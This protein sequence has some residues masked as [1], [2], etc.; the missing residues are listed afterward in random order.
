[1]DAIGLLFSNAAAHCRPELQSVI[2]MMDSL[3]PVCTN[4]TSEH[5]LRRSF[6]PEGRV[7]SLLAC[8]VQRD[9]RFA[10]YAGL[11]NPST[12]KTFLCGP[13]PHTPPPEPPDAVTEEIV[14]VAVAVVVL[15]GIACWAVAR[16][17]WQRRRG[18][19]LAWWLALAVACG[20]TASK[21]DR[22][23]DVNDF[24]VR[25]RV[26]DCAFQV[27]DVV[28]R[29]VAKDHSFTVISPATAAVDAL[30]RVLRTPVATERGP[31]TLYEEC[32][33]CG[34]TAWN[35]SEMPSPSLVRT[36]ILSDAPAVHGDVAFSLQLPP[37][38]DDASRTSFVR[39]L[40]V[41][42][43]DVLFANVQQTMI[44]SEASA[45]PDLWIMAS[46]AGLLFAF[47]EGGARAYVTSGSV[48]LTTCAVF[49][50]G[51]TVVISTAISSLTRV[52]PSPFNML[53]FPLVLGTGVD[54]LFLFLHQR[55]RHGR[56]WIGRTLPSVAA[57]QL[58]TLATFLVG[59]VVDIPHVRYF[60]VFMAV[61]VVVS[62]A[63]QVTALPAAIVLC[64]RARVPPREQQARPR[65]TWR[66]A[67]PIVAAVVLWSVVILYHQPVGKRFDLRTQLRE[68]TMTHRFMAAMDGVMESPMALVYALTDGFDDG[69][70][71][72][73]VDETA[74]GWD[75]A[76]G[77]RSM[78]WHA[79]M[80]PGV[81]LR[82]WLNDTRVRYT[83]QPFLNT[84]AQSSVALFVSG[85]DMGVDAGRSFD[86]LTCMAERSTNR[87]CFASFERLGGY[88]VVKLV[89][90][91]RWLAAVSCVLCTA[92]GG[93]VLR[94]RGV[95]ALLALALSYG[96]V[97][98]VMSMSGIPIDMLLVAVMLIAPGLVVDYT[99]HL[100]F[101]RDATLAV[102]LSSASSVASALPYLA[103][104]VEGI[105][106]FVVVY[107]LFLVLGVLHAFALTATTELV[108]AYH[109]VRTAEEEESRSTP[110]SSKSVRAKGQEL[111]RA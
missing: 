60:F 52:P 89:E 93:V 96:G 99:L 11:L 66:L 90:H 20:P 77:M 34:L 12:L 68:D 74:L 103:M 10:L 57:S 25:D 18:Q 97:V 84:A 44:D 95:L 75:C 41:G 51:I 4:V 55:S 46:S 13:P 28:P 1:M 53:G 5:A 71:W 8:A 45:Q 9:A 83:V 30:D 36:L 21:V 31:T 104:P 15:L 39:D 78:S 98:G 63:L 26:T 79:Q 59:V 111:L 23:V 24:I 65:S 54:S 91:L 106:H 64:S 70:E 40:D 110:E 73:T 43:D 37:S 19:I 50:L 69:A 61:C 32:G 38:M 3:P 29:V 27:T 92:V 76:P 100:L 109:S 22:R 47:A 6:L 102:L 80:P 87:T 67:A 49:L 14:P 35:R 16:G 81:P 58:S 48:A 101:H 82:E 33:M 88:T 56:R 85:F 94:G 7:H 107:A 105:R 42:S 2:D 17:G 86:E 62:F 72:S 108:V